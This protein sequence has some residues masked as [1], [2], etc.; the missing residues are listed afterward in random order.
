MH[1]IKLHN[2]KSS[3]IRKS[4]NFLYIVKLLFC[5]YIKMDLIFYFLPCA[6]EFV[7]GFWK[8]QLYTILDPIGQG[9][10]VLLRPQRNRSLYGIWNMLRTKTIQLKIWKI[11]SFDVLITV[12]E[13]NFDSQNFSESLLFLIFNF[14]YKLRNLA[15]R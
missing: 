3:R 12:S 5:R 2:T 6:N 10:M 8:K 1:K 14:S 13:K 9:W 4:L 15:G 11:K 7:L